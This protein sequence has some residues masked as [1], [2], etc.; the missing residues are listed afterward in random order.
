V[1][2]LAFGIFGLMVSHPATDQVVGELL[3][4]TQIFT[5][6]GFYESTPNSAKFEQAFSEDGGKTWETK[7]VMSFEREK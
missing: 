3:D 6:N 7:W 2:A 5:Q 1:T 4:G